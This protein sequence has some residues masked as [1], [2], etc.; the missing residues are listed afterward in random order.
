VS[1]YSPDHEADDGN[2]AA[3]ARPAPSQDA[4]TSAVPPHP[5]CRPGL[6]GHVTR[7]HLGLATLAASMHATR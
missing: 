1:G 6:Q 4:G 5:I 7:R 3:P 2:A